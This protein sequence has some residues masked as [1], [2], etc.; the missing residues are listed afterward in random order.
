MNEMCEGTARIV[1]NDG[2]VINHYVSWDTEAGLE[3]HADRLMAEYDVSEISI[4]EEQMNSVVF[5]GLHVTF[6]ARPGSAVR[7][8]LAEKSPENAVPQSAEFLLDLFLSAK[9]RDEVL[10][11]LQEQYAK[12]V[13][14]YG[15][16][17]AKIWLYKQVG[18]SM[19]PLLWKLITLGLGK[20]IRR[21]IS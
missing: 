12:R 14:K 16:V 2:R 1:L 10:G 3:G 8:R 15:H 21:H 9:D 7:R 6:T 13:T 4:T 18:A 20:W 5:H 11:D 19:L 17:K